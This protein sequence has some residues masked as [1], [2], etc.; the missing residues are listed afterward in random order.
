MDP[1]HLTFESWNRLASLYQ[2]QF[3]QVDLYDDTY[4]RFCQLLP[5]THPKVLEIGCGPGN[6]TRYLLDKRPDMY[7]EA[8]D[9]APNMV[10][11]AQQNNPSAHFRVMD[12]RDLGALTGRYNGIMCGFCLPYL[13]EGDCLKL[14]GDCADRLLPGGVLY[15]SAIEGPYSMSGIERGSSVTEAMYVYYYEEP[16]LRQALEKNSFEVKEVIRKVYVRAGRPD[17][18]N[19]ILIAVRP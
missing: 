18:N 5:P 9:V 13:S 19:I 10:E 11:L 12:C 4:D 17:S 3:M 15:V 2:E 7:L 16:F 1:Y 8:L 6:I 14:F